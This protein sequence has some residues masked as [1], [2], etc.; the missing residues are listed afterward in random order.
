M[1]KLTILIAF[2]AIIGT[3]FQA[4]SQ[5]L[6]ESAKRKVTVGVDVFTDIWIF[7]NDPLYMSQGFDLRTV[8][9]GATGFVMYNLQVGKGL[10][11]FSIG[12]GI[13]NHNMYSNSVISDIKADTIVFEEIEATVS[14]YRKSKVNFTYID[15]PAEFKFRTEGGF[16]LGVGLKVGYMIDSKQK[17]KGN[18]PEDGKNV[19]VKTKDINQLEKWSFGPTLRIGFK[20]VSLYGYYQITQIYKTDRGPVMNPISVGLTITPF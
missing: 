5:V 19:L 8:Q 14:D 1:K 2:L 6:S 16:K 3:S 4:S 13:R 12:L 20:W 10:S 17:Y 18:R 11:A 15:L 9:Q 7:T